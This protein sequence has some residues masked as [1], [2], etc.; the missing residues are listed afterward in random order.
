MLTSS[1][2]PPSLSSPPF[3]S[4]PILPLSLSP[5]PS[6]P[7]SPPPPPPPS[8]PSPPLSSPP[9]PRSLSLSPSP[10][11]PP[12]LLFFPLPPPLPPPYLP[13][14]SPPPSPPL[15]PMPI[16]SYELCRFPFPRHH[17]HAGENAPM[18]RKARRTLP[19]SYAASLLLVPLAALQAAES[20]SARPN[21]PH[22]PRRR[23]GILRPRLL[24][25]GDRHAESRPAG[26]R[27]TAVH[28][29]LQ[30]GP[31][32]AHAQRAADRLLSAADPHGSAAGAAAVMDP[33]AAATAQA[34]GLSQ[35]PF[36]QVARQ[37]RTKPVAD[38]GFDHS[39]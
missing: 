32:L 17:Q 15:R 29:V 16:A 22:H 39:Y 11:S 2:P 5:L 36:R 20:K 12:L 38:G 24:R 37:R 34:A 30:H 31:L 9:L 13:S 33:H 4:L 6:F 1:L 23:P 19:G 10:L 27:R 14:P 26:G 28:P 35:L 21:Y 8:P 3:P 25:L 7:T 18:N